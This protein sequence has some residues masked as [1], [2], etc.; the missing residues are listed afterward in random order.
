MLRTYRI[1][2]YPT[3]EQ[4]KK[5]AVQ[6]GCARWAW[7][8]AL[9]ETQRL[10]RE[11]GKGLGYAAMTARLPIL[12]EQ[13]PW[14]LEADSQVLQQ[15]LRNLS[16]AFINFFERRARYPRFKSKHGRQSIQ[17][18]QRVRVAEAQDNGASRIYLPKAGWVK[19]IVHQPWQG[20]IKTVT[21]SLGSDGRYHASVLVEDGAEAPVVHAN[22]K[23]LGIDV[24]LTH[25]AVTS[26]GSKFDNPRHV[27][28]AEKNLARKQQKL[29]RKQKGSNGRAKAR[30]CVARAHARVANA[31][32]DYL[33]KLSR[34]LVDENQ[35]IAVEDLNVKGMTQ[36]PNLAKSINDAGWGMLTRFMEYKARNAGKLFLRVNRFYPSSKTCSCCGW[37]EDVMPL[38]RRFWACS[39]CNSHHDRDVNAAI[40][41]RDEAQRLIAAGTVA[42]DDG[43]GVRRGKGRKSSVAQPPVKSEA[44]AFRPE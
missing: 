33:H 10:Y 7:N 30:R 23:M 8:E 12:K 27:L 4:Q 18:P 11:T 28:R 5:L 14:L 34:R 20:A 22:G 17:Y 1:R 41:I 19:C 6:F 31:R 13:L 44:S 25:L 24:G 32:A 39:R 3:A 9:A 16:G 36:N 21:V 43:G 38:S 2:L 15:S 35:V 29:A 40:N 37:V 26:D 42:T